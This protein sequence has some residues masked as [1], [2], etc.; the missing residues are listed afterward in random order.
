[1][2]LANSAHESRPWRIREIAP[3]FTLEDVWA[4]PVHGGVE[5]FQD[6]IELLANLDPAGSGSTPSRLLFGVRNRLG[7]WFGWDD[8]TNQLPIPGATETTLRERLPDDL[9]DSVKDLDVPTSPFIPVY[10]TDDEWAAELSNHTV[11]AIMHIVWIDK[12]DGRYQ[13][14]MGVYVKPRGRF[15]PAYMA[16]IAPFRHRIVYPALMRQIER[17]WNRRQT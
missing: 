11:H 17:A 13:G 16:F 4:L 12:G 15:G 8:D 5:D 2:R 9:R 1:M 14:Q 6:L 7:D 10:Q 3:D